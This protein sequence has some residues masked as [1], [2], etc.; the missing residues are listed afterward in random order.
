M[1]SMTRQDHIDPLIASV[2]PCQAPGHRNGEVQV[3]FVNG[4][5]VCSSCH[6]S[7]YAEVPYLRRPELDVVAWVAANVKDV[8]RSLPT[9]LCTHHE[10]GPPYDRFAE[11]GWEG[12]LWLDGEDHS[13]LKLCLPRT[14]G[15]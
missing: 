2:A 13:T 15:G 9:K 14:N 5:W 6:V 7:D 1:W 8:A 12:H 10:M 4:A 3:L 11:W